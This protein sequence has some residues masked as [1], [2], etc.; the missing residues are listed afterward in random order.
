MALAYSAILR[1][2]IA[3]TSTSLSFANFYEFASGAGSGEVSVV[4][5][6]GVIKTSLESSYG[7]TF[8][9]VVTTD[10][11]FTYYTMAWTGLSSDPALDNNTGNPVSMYIYDF[12]GGGQASTAF[13]SNEQCEATGSCRTCPPSV[14]PEDATDCPTCYPMEIAF[15]DASIDILGLEDSTEYDFEIVD[16]AT[17]RVYTYT[18]TTDVFGGAEII[19]AD[20]PTGLFTPYNGAF[21]IS[22]FDTNGDPVTLTYGYV[23]YA[24][25]ELTV[26]NQT[27]YTP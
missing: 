14:N 18:T 7:G 6:L 8:S 5:V 17:G 20:F 27:D 10:A 2:P 4:A 13:F 19:T 15:C 22:V 21:T 9:W 25:I 16:Q 12:D 26:N 3:Y 1:V 24:C 23:N 11:T